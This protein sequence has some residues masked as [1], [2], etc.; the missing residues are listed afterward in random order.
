MK[1]LKSSSQLEK[2]WRQCCQTFQEKTIYMQTRITPAKFVSL[3]ESTSLDPSFMSALIAVL[4]DHVDVSTEEKQQQDAEV[5]Y[6][7]SNSTDR[8]KFILQ[9]ME[10]LPNCGRFELNISFMDKKE[11]QS[12]KHIIHWLGDALSS[13]TSY[14][15][16]ISWLQTAYSFKKID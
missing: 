10:A 12:V 11:K 6:F 15:D 8:S 2:D 9:W 16:R 13:D 7:F 4:Y 5:A 1:H 14:A 3:Y